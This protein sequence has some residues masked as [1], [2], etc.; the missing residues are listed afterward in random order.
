VD[1]VITFKGKPVIGL[2]DST[3]TAITAGVV[4]TQ[5]IPKRTILRL[6][7]VEGRDPATPAILKTLVLR[8]ELPSVFDPAGAASPDVIVLAQLDD[9]S[10]ATIPGFFT[11]VDNVRSQL[12]SDN[13]ET[14]T[15]AIT[16]P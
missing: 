2:V 14:L 16:F 4:P 13:D 6:R 8:M 10:D 11:Y 1:G 7:V 3:G 12:S 9:P 5:V 15:F